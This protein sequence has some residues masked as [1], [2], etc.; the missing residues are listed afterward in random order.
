MAIHVPFLGVR[1]FISNGSLWVGTSEEPLVSY[2]GTSNWDQLARDALEALAALPALS[3]LTIIIPP[4]WQYDSH[5]DVPFQD[6]WTHVHEDDDEWI[7]GS[8][9]PIWEALKEFTHLRPMVKLTS[10]RLWLDEDDSEINRLN[11]ERCLTKLRDRLGIWDCKNARVGADGAWTV[12]AECAGEDPDE[13][14]LYLRFL[15]EDDTWYAVQRA[16]IE[17]WP[18][19]KIL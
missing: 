16:R 14:L 12:P 9:E 17:E 1:P 13:Y 6:E 7:K 10:V 19:G 5:A 18:Q 4:D 15:F 3:H 8:N 11:H 2:D